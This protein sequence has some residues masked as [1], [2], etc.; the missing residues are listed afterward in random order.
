LGSLRDLVL[1]IF[2]KRCLLINLII[3]EL[4]KKYLVLRSLEE[5]YLNLR[6]LLNLFNCSFENDVGF[7]TESFPCI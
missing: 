6:I 4:G 7:G 3:L 2:D 5:E 1:L